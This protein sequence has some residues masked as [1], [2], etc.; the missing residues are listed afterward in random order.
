M[1]AC[2]IKTFCVFF[3]SG[4]SSNAQCLGNVPIS[5][6]IDTTTLNKMVYT[7]D[8]QCKFIFGPNAT[9]CPTQTLT[10]CSKLYCLPS[11]NAS[12]QECVSTTNDAALDGTICDSGKVCMMGVCSQSNLAP[13]DSCPFGDAHI[14][15]KLV[16]FN[17]KLANRI[18]CADAFAIISANK[19]SIE[20][21]CS[22]NNFKTYCCQ[23]CKKYNALTC[24]DTYP[25]CSAYNLNYCAEGVWGDGRL[26]REVCPRTCQS[27]TGSLYCKN[28]TFICQ[29][30]AVCQNLTN[31]Y[32]NGFKCICDARFTGELCETSIYLK[33]LQ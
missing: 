21:Y 4:L 13:V 8:E 14:Y 1:Y 15:P 27:C 3:D 18:S 17:S 2:I 11:L 20:V 23:S 30:G 33:K 29:N 10:I 22:Q 31:A 12:I 9:F 16:D 5:L 25:T 6:P 7:A 26:F 19:G 24:V 32:Q 28:G